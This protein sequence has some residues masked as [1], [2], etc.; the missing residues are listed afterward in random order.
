M[1]DLQKHIQNAKDH[2]DKSIHHFT[3][4]LAKVRA[5]RAMPNMLDGI[6]IDYYGTPTPVSQVASVTTPDA[7]TLSIKPWEK[8]IIHDIERA[9]INS[10]LGLNPQSD[11][12]S[13]RL[14]IPVL[15]EERR[16][17]LVKQVKNEAEHARVSIRNI[18]KDANEHIK[19]LVKESVSEDEVKKAELRIQELTDGSIKKIDELAAGKEKEIM[20]V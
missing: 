9:I 7:R 17:D 10:D 8:K 6:M 15:T 11:G 3:H 19:K 12:E 13:V 4:T 16:R 1:E 14:N 2:M 20:T 18:R 5:G